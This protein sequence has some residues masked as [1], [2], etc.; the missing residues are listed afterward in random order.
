M[1]TDEQKKLRLE[2][3]GGSEIAALAGLNPHM[4]A[5][6]VYRC[7]VEGFEPPQ[8][9]HMERG[10][11]LEDGVARWYAH[12]TGA[13]LRE[14]GTIRHPSIAR[15]ICTPDRLA[16]PPQGEEV[17]LS[18]KFPGIRSAAYWGEPGTDDV[19]E[20][21]WCQVQWE[22]IPLG[23]L[24]G[25]RRAHIAAPI[26]GD[27]RVYTVSG[28]PKAQAHLAEIAQKFWVDH[29]AKKVPPPIDG[30]DS[31]KAWL[32]DRFPENRTPLKIAPPEATELAQRYR[33][34]RR[35]REEHEKLEKECQNRLKELIGD[36]EGI[37]GQ[38]WFATWKAPKG[39]L[40]IDWEAIARALNPPDELIQ[41]H[42][43]LSQPTR[44][45]LFKDQSK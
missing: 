37:K 20:A 1:L 17:D 31:A 36:A 29:V 24:Y 34:H 2:G 18:I 44:R 6:D 33:E 21:Y 42:T 32:H 16:T 41:R 45:F 22:L 15:I 26:D 30:S 28:D 25:I 23:V 27:L 5:L 43:G 11:F 14:V 4:T 38:G 13:K 12:R 19:P 9:H 7:K 40:F 39:S 3:I 35:A 10:T 8:T